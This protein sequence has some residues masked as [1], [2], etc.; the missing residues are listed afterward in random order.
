MGSK[1]LTSLN[2]FIL[3]LNARNRD[4]LYFKAIKNMFVE[5]IFFEYWV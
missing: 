3:N 2:H 4:K 1:Y 5:K